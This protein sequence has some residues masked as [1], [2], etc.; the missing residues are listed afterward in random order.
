MTNDPRH[1][2]HERVRSIEGRLEQFER[3]SDRRF[4]N[5]ATEVREVGLDVREIKGALIG[6][7]KHTGLAGEVKMLLYRITQVEAAQ[8]ERR[9]REWGLWSAVFLLGVSQ[10]V[11]AIIAGRLTP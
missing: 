8:A 2:L 5:I 10:V 11:A 4:G 3:D 6:D 7:G 1:D 9:K